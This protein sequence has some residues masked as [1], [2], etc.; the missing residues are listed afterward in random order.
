MGSSQIMLRPGRELRRMGIRKNLMG[1]L[2]DSLAPFETPEAA[3]DR[4][5]ARGLGMD[6]DQPNAFLTRKRTGLF[7]VRR[8]RVIVFLACCKKFKKPVRLV[9]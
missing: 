6:F 3:W 1:K 8:L 5:G 7:G 4:V 2:A 9:G